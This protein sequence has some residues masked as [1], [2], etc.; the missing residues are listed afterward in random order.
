MKQN[1]M[2]IHTI[3][4]VIAFIILS[5]SIF[6]MLAGHNAPG[7]GFIGGLMTASAFLVL[8]ISFGMDEIDKV[9]RIDFTYLIGIGMLFAIG[10][11]LNSILFDDPFLTHYFDEYLLP[12]LGEV[13]LT[14]ALPFDL[15]V[16]FV[17]VSSAM[18]IIL[19]IARD[20]T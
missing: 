14:T 9:I 5:F 4:R 1:S 12:I 8:Y 13:E 10:T 3:T 2:M 6:I 16:Y 11:G 15:G 19:T 7:G 17:V 20:R 18:L